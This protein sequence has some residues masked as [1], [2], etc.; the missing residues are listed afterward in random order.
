MP[1][2]IEDSLE[3]QLGA[4]PLEVF[5]LYNG[6]ITLLYDDDAHKYFIDGPD[7]RFQ[8]P[9]VTT[10]LDTLDKSNPLIAWAVR[11]TITSLEESL[12][13]DSRADGSIF[14]FLKE[15]L[16]EK[17]ETARK[18]HRVRKDDA[19]NIGKQ[20]HKW[21]EKYGLLIIKGR[22][23]E[24]A[25]EELLAQ[26]PNDARALSCISAALAWY[27]EHH[28]VFIECERKV[29]SREDNSCGTTDVIAMVDGKRSLLDY[30]SSNGLYDTNRF[31]LA[32]YQSA[33]QEET[34]QNIEQRILL[35]LGKDEGEFEAHVLA[36]HDEYL[37][38]LMA[39]KGLL[40]TYERVQEIKVKAAAA[41]AEAKVAAREAKEEA[42]ALEKAAKAEAKAAKNK[43]T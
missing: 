9:N 34:G 2:E 39:Y 38:D 28:V 22:T 7:G 30:K 27:K 15:E 13:L 24:Q 32:F 40:I 3:S 8:V 35:R 6:E 21:L 42:K 14:E 43:A 20:A 18:A 31:Q 29:Y 37:A 11:C 41:R 36:D 16:V 1:I 33:Y 12:H 23:D 25:R 4:K 17:L 10:V 26:A 19:A 5:K